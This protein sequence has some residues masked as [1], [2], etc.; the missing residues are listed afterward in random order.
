[1]TKFYSPDLSDK[2]LV[3]AA[4]HLKSLGYEEVVND[5][6]ADF[7]L[8][9]INY[10]KKYLNSDVPVID[11]KKE[12]VF[13]LKNAYLTAEAALA[14]TIDE[15]ESSLINSSLLIVGYGRIGKALHK[16]L[17]AFTSNITVCA[18][19]E[20]ARA[21]ALSN[22]AKTIDFSELKNCSNYDVIYNTV[23]H[24]VFNEQELSSV[25]RDSLI[26]DLAS[27][28][29]GVDKHIAKSKGVNL[30]IARGLP[31]KYSPKAAGIVVAQTID[32]MI[33]GV[34]K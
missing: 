19:N 7:L 15:S 20:Q 11:Y 5:K 26:I 23:P 18:R 24:P 3:Y 1:M 29:G 8:L 30:I 14:L 31:G 6:N 34:I 27:F 33:K 25:S 22:N 10:D 17:S 21:L 13:Q 4:E 28:P 16:Y 32:K 9:G 12:E 2:R